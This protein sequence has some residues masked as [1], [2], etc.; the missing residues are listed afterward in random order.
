ML[1]TRTTKGQKG[2]KKKPQL[3]TGPARVPAMTV[4][5]LYR[6]WQGY[7]SSK[8]DVSFVE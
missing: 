6:I 5:T 3:V 4:F 1:V 8:I 2:K 7:S